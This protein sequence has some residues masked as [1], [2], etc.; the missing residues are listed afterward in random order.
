M[1]IYKFTNKLLVTLFNPFFL[2]LLNN[3]STPRPLACTFIVCRPSQNK[4]CVD[5]CKVCWCPFVRIIYVYMYSLSYL[6]NTTA[7][8]ACIQKTMCRIIAIHFL[9]THRTIHICIG[10][11][12]DEDDEETAVAYSC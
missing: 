2:F 3:H 10:P 4:N 5:V 12:A 6:F 7:A 8:T 1:N 11:S 9:R